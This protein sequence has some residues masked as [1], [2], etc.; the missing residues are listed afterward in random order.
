MLKSLLIAA[1]AAGLLAACATPSSQPD[2]AREA[3]AAPRLNCLTTGTRIRLKDGECAN[4]AGRVYTKDDL[5]R[6]GAITTEEALR[7]LDPSL[8]R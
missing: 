7:L 4:S 3:A 8:S 5:D 6:T 1:T 2:L